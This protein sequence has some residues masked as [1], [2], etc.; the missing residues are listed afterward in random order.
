MHAALGDTQPLLRVSGG[1]Q[2]R[3]QLPQAIAHGCVVFE[4]IALVDSRRGEA[5]GRLWK[6]RRGGRLA[7]REPPP[8]VVQQ[9]A[10]LGQRLRVALANARSM[11]PHHQRQVR[12]PGHG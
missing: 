11:L 5:H 1:R 9:L 7:A 4:P 8:N 10:H 12:V 3:V 2:H 6:V